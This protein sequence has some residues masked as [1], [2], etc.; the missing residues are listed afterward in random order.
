MNQKPDWIGQ[1]SV[2]LLQEAK[3]H[4]WAKKRGKPHLP[5]SLPVPYPS[6][7]AGYRFKKVVRSQVLKAPGDD[8]VFARQHLGHHRLQVIENAPPKAAK[9]GKRL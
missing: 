5:G 2:Q 8:L 6:R 7:G 9:E 1:L 3:R 4:R